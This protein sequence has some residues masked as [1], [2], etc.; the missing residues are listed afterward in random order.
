MKD[1]RFSAINWPLLALITLTGTF[2]AAMPV[3][4]MPVLFKEISDDLGLDLVQVGTIWG[5]TN[6]AGI[7]VSV[8][9][10]VI[11]DRFGLRRVLALFCILVGITGALRGISGS[12]SALAVTVF[13]NGV[14][15]LVVPIAA[16]K[17]IGVW[18]K[19]PRLGTAMGVS[20]MGIGLGLTLGPMISATVLSPL[21]GGWRNVMYFYGAISALVGVTW[22]FSGKESAAVSAA[23]ASSRAPALKTISRLVRLKAIWLI[24]FGILF[25]IACIIGVTGYLPI[26]LR[27]QGWST[28]AAD[29]TLAIFY[30]ASAALV[31][32]LSLMSDRLRSRKAVMIPAAA[33]TTVAVSLLPLVDG[34]AVWVLAALAGMFLDG[35]M[36]IVVTTLLETEEIGPAFS[37][38]ALGMIFSISQIGAVVS[39]PFGNGL[40]DIG[41]GVPFFF[42][43]GLSLISLLV[44][45]TVRET[46]GRARNITTIVRR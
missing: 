4:C 37:G 23:A 10:G 5:I 6:L 36:S 34:A 17:A 24:S 39:P 46:A 42:W 30:A 9:G 7:F 22:A 40:A 25:R 20:A 35:F 26:Y 13:I 15:R 45:L 11:A 19:G 1:I 29:G 3:S 32:P 38:T 16:S 14:V 27:G 12:F 44:L 21:L 18:F 8:I 41:A 2:V 31:I 28:A 43:A 33:V